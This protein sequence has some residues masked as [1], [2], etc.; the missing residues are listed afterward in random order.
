M[1]IGVIPKI[2]ADGLAIIRN[3]AAERLTRNTAT[4][5]RKKLVAVLVKCDALGAALADLE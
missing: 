3:Y 4:K 2:P 5:A 1:T